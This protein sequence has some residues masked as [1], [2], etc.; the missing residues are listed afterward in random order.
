M[1]SRIHGG[2][3]QRCTSDGFSPHVQSAQRC[4]GDYGITASYWREDASQRM[5]TSNIEI[6]IKAEAL[7]KVCIQKP[8]SL[9][10]AWGEKNLLIVA[11]NLIITPISFK[12][13]LCHK[14]NMTAAHN[15]E[16]LTLESFS[17]RSLC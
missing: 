8:P 15:D 13:G 14:E 2:D 11:T 4:P 10:Q 6:K 5:T 3:N 17:R 9:K 16:T 7:C 1:G 12:S